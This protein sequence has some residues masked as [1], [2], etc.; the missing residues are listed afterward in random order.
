MKILRSL[1]VAVLLISGSGY[2]VAQEVLA[3]AIYL[4]DSGNGFR[5]TLAPGTLTADQEFEFPAVGGKFLVQPAAVPTVGQILKV[6]SV[7][8]GPAPTYDVTLEWAEP[9]TPLYT[10][11]TADADN[12]DETTTTS[13]LSL[14]VEANTTY[15]V[16]VRFNYTSPNVG[17]DVN[18]DFDAPTGATFS[19]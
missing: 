11:A 18:W 14:S 17:T 19:S 8:P 6:A 3:N 16:E 1:A 9:S 4:V 15:L 2:A 5:L 7:S 10:V 13:A 12:D